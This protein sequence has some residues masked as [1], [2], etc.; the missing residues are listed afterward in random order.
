MRKQKQEEYKGY[1]TAGIRLME[2][3][4]AGL[5]AFSEGQD[6]GALYPY[7]LFDK[8]HLVML[9]EEALIPKTDV[10]L[11]LKELRSTEP[12]KIVESRMEA[13]GAMH[14]GEYLLIRR[15]GEEVGGRM[16]LGRSSG[17]LHAVWRRCRQRDGLIMLMGEINRLRGVFLQVAG[18]NLESVM[19]AYTHS[20]H[21]Q[22]TTL[23]HQLLAWTSSLERCF[24]R[25][26]FAYSW[27]NQSPAGSAIMTGSDF[28]LNRHRTAELMGFDGVLPNTYDA[29]LNE[30]TPLDTF[31]AVAT[32]HLNLSRWASDLNF[33]FTSEAG[34]VDVPDRFCGTSSIMM[35]KKNPD[36]LEYVRGAVAD[37]MGGLVASFAVQKAAS[38]DPTMDLRYMDDA[39]FRSFDMAIRN[40]GWFIELMPALEVKKERMRE[41]AGA[42]WAQAT[43][44]AG[45]LVREKG[46]PW[47]T[48]HQIVGILVRFTEERGIRPLD[49][50]PDLLDEA[51]VEYMG[52]GVG[53]SEEALA[54]ALDPMA[55]VER[56]TLYGGPAPEECRRRMVEYEARLREDEESVE[57]RKRRL[58]E[59]AGKLES[60]ID[61]IIG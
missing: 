8:A 29:I 35:Q 1:R 31:M 9:A 36:S 4:L 44:V 59:S 53:L 56:R 3:M 38:G 40:L 20:Q 27:A 13:G 6:E 30:D 37:A 61:A 18:E 43:D 26:A 32:V 23:G 48:A 57:E 22:P 49:V 60:A 19:P 28:P 25:A 17:D 55:F 33:W 45:A 11:M 12:D 24:G 39:L 2:P 42:H 14:S 47:R 16:H 58:D 21:A 15:L 34:Y 7:H 51:S 52:E 50:T 41:M 10:A 54:R 5:P 46:L